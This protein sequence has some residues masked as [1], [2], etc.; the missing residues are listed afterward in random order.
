MP[1]LTVKDAICLSMQSREVHEIGDS[2]LYNGNIYYVQQV[3]SDYIGQELI[4][5]YYFRSKEGMKVLPLTHKNISG[6]SFEASVIDVKKNK[7][8]IKI[9]QDENK[10]QSNQKWFLYETVYSSPD[11]T[12]WYCMP[13]IGDSVRLYVPEKESNSFVISSVHKDNCEFRQNPDYKSFRT[14]YGK[15]IL[16]TPDTMIMTNNNGLIIELSDK[17]GIFIGSDKEIVIQSEDKL[18][19]AS[20][21]A[22]LLV[23]AQ[24]RLQMRQGGTT[25]TL[26]EDITFTGEEFRIQ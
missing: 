4:H 9:E 10:R 24:D 23:A 14:K 19:I 7:V 8:K 2:I 6:C 11:G 13:E 22:S 25:M 20:Q 1:Q 16:M 15:E 17:E 3:V 12:G 21:E 26:D 5:S 18:T